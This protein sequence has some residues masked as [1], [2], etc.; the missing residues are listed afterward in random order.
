MA[1]YRKFGVQQALI[2]GD[3][4]FVRGFRL[5]GF[6]GQDLVDIIADACTS[7]AESEILQGR[8]ENDPSTP[9]DVYL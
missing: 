3:F 6:L 7:M 1:A 2:A 8:Y 4:L 5:G 9:V